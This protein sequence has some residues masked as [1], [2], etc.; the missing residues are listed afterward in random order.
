MGRCQAGFCL[1]RVL[2]I[3]NRELGISKEL[4]TKNGGESFILSDKVKEWQK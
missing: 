3:I 4:V 1:P 2:A